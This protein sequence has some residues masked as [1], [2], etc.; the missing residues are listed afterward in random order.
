MSDRPTELAQRRTVLREKAA[1]QRQQL[2]LQLGALESR[3]RSVD[4]GLMRAN[5]FLRKPV[6][7]VGSA[8][9]LYFLGPRRVLSMVGRATFL[10]STGRQLLGLVKAR[11]GNSA[12]E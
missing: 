9:L 11:R 1:Q 4:G 5:L 6:L 10:I 8:A 12:P 3:I 7:W 2:G